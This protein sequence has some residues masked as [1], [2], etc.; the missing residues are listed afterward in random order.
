M[1]LH[2]VIF[3]VAEFFYKNELKFKAINQ[4]DHVA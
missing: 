1:H 3:R 2:K 4:P